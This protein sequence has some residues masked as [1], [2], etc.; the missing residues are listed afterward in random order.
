MQVVS[1][2]IT[3][4]QLAANRGDQKSCTSFGSWE[5]ALKIFDTSQSG[6]KKNLILLA[7][8]D[9][10]I[11]AGPDTPTLS[12]HAQEIVIISKLDRKKMNQLLY[13]FLWC[14]RFVSLAG[15]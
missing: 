13:N 8:K 10:W 15:K 12:N 6:K 4:Y 11:P 3:Y 7:F 5:V 14:L 1:L 2:P 9:S